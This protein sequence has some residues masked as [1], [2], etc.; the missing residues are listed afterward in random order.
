LLGKFD[1]DSI[2]IMNVDGNCATKKAQFRTRV[3]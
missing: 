3:R 1:S 2:T